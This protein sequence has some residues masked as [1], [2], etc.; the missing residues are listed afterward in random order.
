[1]N[2]NEENIRFIGELCKFKIASVFTCLKACLDDFTHHNIED[3][4]N[5]LETCGLFL[6]LSPETIVRMANML[7]DIDAL[8]EC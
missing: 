3:A 1:M 2:Q 8:E 5:L 6:Y 7:G 4:C